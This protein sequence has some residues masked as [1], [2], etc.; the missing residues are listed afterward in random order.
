MQMI[1]W[2][3]IDGKW[4]DEPDILELE[5]KGYHMVVLRHRE[6]GTLNGYVGVNIHHP[7]FGTD[8]DQKKVNGI[9]VHGGLTFSALGSSMH[10]APFKKNFW[11]FGF[12]TA[13]AFDLV[14]SMIALKQSIPTLANMAKDDTYRDLNYVSD[15]VNKL[16]DQLQD[17]AA[18]S[19]DHKINHK[20]IYRKLNKMK[21]RCL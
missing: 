11:Y 19:P 10:E 21:K 16:K 3:D 2:K 18:S 17:I 9:M 13:H 12:D 6:F 4:N 15:Y 7:A 20:K 8:Y 5:G 14:P 1:S